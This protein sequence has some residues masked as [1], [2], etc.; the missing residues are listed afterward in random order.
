[1]VGL[2]ATTV[3]TQTP[4]L[5]SK[6]SLLLQNP[7]PRSHVKESHSLL[8][9]RSRLEHKWKR[10]VLGSSAGCKWCLAYVEKAPQKL[11]EAGEPPGSAKACML[12]VALPLNVGALAR[13][14]LCREYSAHA[15]SPE[16]WVR[17]RFR[18]SPARQGC[19]KDR[20]PDRQV[21]VLGVSRLAG[22]ESVRWGLLQVLQDR[23]V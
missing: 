1:M 20:N 13:N 6:A 14:A 17:G 18:R 16:G 10:R 5:L 8:T 7:A 3:W 9:L 21:E 19:S 23:V 12:H 11:H 2:G 22:T 15:H 4:G